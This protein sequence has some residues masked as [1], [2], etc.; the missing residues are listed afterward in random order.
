MARFVDYTLALNGFGVHGCLVFLYSVASE[1]LLAD[2][3]S[4]LWRKCYPIS[5]W[6]HFCFWNCPPVLDLR[7]E[8]EEVLGEY[9]LF[10]LFVLFRFGVL[11]LFPSVFLFDLVASTRLL[12]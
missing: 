8:D 2:F 6:F 1:V 5:T 9:H 12:L 3:V 4:F 7:E 11:F 10:V